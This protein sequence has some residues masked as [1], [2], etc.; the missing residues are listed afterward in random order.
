[1]ANI[2]R[3]KVGTNDPLDICNGV[4]IFPQAGSFS[5]GIN[6]SN[7]TKPLIDANHRILLWK[8]DIYFYYNLEVGLCGPAW[9]TWLDVD[10][11]TSGNEVYLTI[12]DDE[13]SA[14]FFLGAIFTLGL[15]ANLWM[16]VPHFTCS[17]WHPRLY[18][19]WSSKMGFN[20]AVRI[21]FIQILFSL[22]EGKLAGEVEDEGQKLGI[23]SF[24]MYAIKRDTFRS[25]DGSFRIEPIMN[26][27]IDILPYIPELG[28]VIEACDDIGANLKSGP[29]VSFG[30]PVDMSLNAVDVDGQ[31]YG[32]LSIDNGSVRGSGPAAAA[33]VSSIGFE[34]KWSP[35]LDFRLGW[36]VSFS[37]W[38][39]FNIGASFTFSVTGILGINT[40]ECINL[41]PV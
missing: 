26:F 4:A 15:R 33:S 36:F 34:F 11:Y 41:H 28:E 25:G 20:E 2:S 35:S 23:H 12:H 22:I 32:S 37:L 27:P 31:T 30:I 14:G 6:L 13:T 16:L 29:M 1:M 17:H 21:D 18:W 3:T 8:Y 38:S 24:S 5:A 9:A 39:L 40:S 10:G 19:T 7:R